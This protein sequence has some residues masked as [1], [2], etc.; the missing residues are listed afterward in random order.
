MKQII[1]FYGT[2]CNPCK[3][4]RPT[5]ESISR[6]IPVRFVDV[7]TE[8]QLVAEYGIRNVPTIVIV[9]NGQAINKASGVLTESQV[10][11]LFN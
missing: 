2:F 10:R 4:F 5:I 7:D 8:P 11:N 3:S 9:Q 1:Y 6:E